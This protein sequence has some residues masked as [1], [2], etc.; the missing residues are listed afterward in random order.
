VLVALLIAAACAALRREDVS[1]TE[2]HA[3]LERAEPAPGS[4]VRPPVNELVMRFTQGVKPSGSWVQVTDS[5]GSRLSG[6]AQFDAADPKV[7][8]FALSNPKP[9]VYTVRWQTLSADDDD[10]FDSSFS[11]TVLNPDGS[12]PDGAG[13]VGDAVNSD[14][15]GDSIPIAAIAGAAGIVLV[16]LFIVLRWRTPSRAESGGGGRS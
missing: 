14:G 12:R 4:E 11:F 1:L 13:V 7:M 5:T 6:D 15:P 9:D 16:A 8:R 3:Q 2:A 10:Y